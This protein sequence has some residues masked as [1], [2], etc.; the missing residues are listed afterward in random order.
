MAR[1]RCSTHRMQLAGGACDYLDRS[2]TGRV[3]LQRLRLLQVTPLFLP[4]VFSQ[5]KLCL[6]FSR[7]CARAHYRVRWILMIA[8]I[9]ASGSRKGRD[10]A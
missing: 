10:V 7:A 5:V 3:C 8:H 1:G 9:A 4:H 2:P 6:I